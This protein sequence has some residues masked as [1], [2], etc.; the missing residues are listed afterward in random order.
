M[1]PKPTSAGAHTPARSLRS[2][3]LRPGVRLMQRLQLKSKLALVTAT[4]MVPLVTLMLLQMGQLLNVRT[5]S[6]SAQRGLQTFG[7]VAPVVT[8]V[9][10]L[11]NLDQLVLRGDAATTAARDSARKG[12]AK[13][14]AAAS[15]AVAVTA[16]QDRQAWQST[17]QTL[18]SLATGTG[19]ANAA[20]SFKAHSQAAQAVQNHLLLNAHQTGLLDDTAPGRR[21]PAQLLSGPLARTPELLSNALAQGLAAMQQGTVSD[22]QRGDLQAQA[23]LLDEATADLQNTMRVWK[24][25]GGQPPLSWPRLQSALFDF[26]LLMRD[27]FSTSPVQGVPKEYLQAGTDVMNQLGLLSDN[28]AGLLLTLHAAQQEQTERQLA[29]VASTFICGLAAMAYLLICF[30]INFQQSVRGLR[31]AADA[32][33]SG[34]LSHTTLV[35]GRDELAAIAAVMDNMSQNL[36]T[37][38]AEIRHSAAL[39]NL[40]GQQVNSG[41]EKLAQRTDDQAGSLRSSITAINQLTVA[42]TSNAEAAQRLD[43]LTEQLAAQAEDGNTAM[44]DTLQAVEQMRLASGRVAEVVSVID[45]VAFQTGMLSLNA[46]IEA[47]RA[48]EAGKGFAVVASE[49]RQL[50]Q[51]CAESAEEIRK[52]IGDAGVQVDESSQKISNVSGALGSIVAGVRQVSQQLRGISSSTAEQSAGLAAVTTSV[53]KLDDIT[54]DNAA[55]VEESSTASHALVER[56]DLLRQAVSSMQLRHGSAEEALALVKKAVQHFGAVGAPQAV[57]NFHDPQGG[58]IDRDLFI[59]GMDRNG[60]FA[61]VGAVPQNVGQPFTIVPGLDKGYLDRVWAAAD[62]GGGWVAYQVEHPFTQVITPKE[63]YFMPCGADLVLGC[64]I[65]RNNLKAGVSGPARVAAPSKKAGRA[66]AAAGR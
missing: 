13:A 61:A 27:T 54:R 37:M 10:T 8:Q 44:Q 38:V 59:I 39:V 42:V 36:S 26:S 9:Q 63:A 53:G 21:Y 62:Q 34:D 23:A 35:H 30:A 1:P 6:V 11:R 41:S 48:G 50:A 45:D 19:A 28:T 20:D 33:A 18:Q 17:V 24:A 46:A 29:L 58:F 57:K 4:L 25:A 55:L 15:A 60:C 51:R 7:A 32:I 14:V 65:Y 40:T 12:L 22:R 3:L 49:V 43:G 64:G 47:A 2:A 16:P 52:L 5:Q 31:R 66:V 56:A